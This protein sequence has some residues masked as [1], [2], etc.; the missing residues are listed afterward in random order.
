MSK[1]LIVGNWKMNLTVAKASLLLHRLHENTQLHKD[2]EVVLAPNFLSLQPLSLEIDRRKFSLAAQNAYSADEGAFTGEVS[3]TQ[4]RG[5][6][7]YVIIGHSERRHILHETNQ[8]IC[9]KVQAAYRNGLKPILCVGE[10]RLERLSGETSRV[11]HDQV[12]KAVAN[13]TAEEAASLVI[14]YE[15]VWAIGSG[16]VAS[17]DE[18]KKAAK[19]IRN[20]ISR[21]FD[22]EVAASIRVLYGG[23]VTPD[24]TSGFIKAEGIDGLLVGGASLNY[25]QFDGIIDSTYR[26]LHGLDQKK[27]Y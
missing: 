14:A 18:A 8:M 11:L 3:F 6:V 10:T 23:S 9:A 19:V 15:P 27:G 1:T 2:I 12:T 24:V 7:K 17:P 4:L 5:L 21:L 20:N 22:K 25:K 26:T 16:E 13:I